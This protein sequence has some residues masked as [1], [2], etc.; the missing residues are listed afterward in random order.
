MA[1]AI[2]LRVRLSWFAKESLFKPGIGWLFR[3]WGGIPI[4]RTEVANRV[5]VMAQRLHAAKSMVLLVS[6]EGTRSRADYW[7]SGFYH[8]AR[9]AN[10]PVVLGF[11]NYATRQV[12][13]GPSITPTSSMQQDMDRIRAFYAEVH[14]RYPELAGPVR[15]RGE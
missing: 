13:F 14:A 1:T 10:V 15:L 6:A 2:V 12:G 5:Q 7:K 11:L 8:I 3:R 9:E 4:R